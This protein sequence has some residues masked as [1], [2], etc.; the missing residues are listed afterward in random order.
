MIDDSYHSGGST[1][2]SEDFGDMEKYRFISIA[3]LHDD[4]S[5][6]FYTQS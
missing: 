5:I 3:G 2:D 1:D 6:R 4:G